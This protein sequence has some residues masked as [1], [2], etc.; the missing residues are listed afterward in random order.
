MIVYKFSHLY[1]L[2]NIFSNLIR[3]EPLLSNKM[4]SREYGRDHP[5]TGGSDL[6]V[7]ASELP[8]DCAAP[9]MR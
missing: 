2:T 4:D 7:E 1:A 5:Y 6:K 8:T 3:F 9:T